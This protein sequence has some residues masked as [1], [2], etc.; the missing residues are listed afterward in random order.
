LIQAHASDEN[1]LDNQ[2]A[3]AQFLQDVARDFFGQPTRR[4]F[5]ASIS[6]VAVAFSFPQASRSILKVAGSVPLTYDD[7]PMPWIMG[8]GMKRLLYHNRIHF[9]FSQ[10][11]AVNNP[12]RYYEQRR[13]EEEKRE[14][15]K[16]DPF[17]PIRNGLIN[18]LSLPIERRFEKQMIE[19]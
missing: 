14:K 2:P 12:D 13:Y 11:I 17:T 16:N 6:K 10:A 8:L 15:E 1:R 5:L 9:L 4:T 18:L 19:W 7:V 3:D